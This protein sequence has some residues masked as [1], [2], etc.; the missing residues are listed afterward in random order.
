MIFYPWYS[1]IFKKIASKNHLLRLR[2]KLKYKK[3]ISF[4]VEESMDFRV[5]LLPFRE[6]MSNYRK[7]YIQVCK[8]DKYS[9]LNKNFLLFYSSVFIRQFLLSINFVTAGE[10]EFYIV[11]FNNRGHQ[12][13]VSFFK[14]FKFLRSFSTGY[15]LTFLDVFKKNL[16]Q[17]LSS[18]ILQFKFVLGV[19]GQ[20]F[21]KNFFIINIKG[22]KPN[23]YKWLNFLKFNLEDFNVLIYVYTPVI[24][25]GNNNIKSVR[26]IKRRLKKKYMYQ[27]R[28]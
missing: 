27:D 10:K 26:A 20:L 15:V 5:I 3:K 4:E 22:T 25:Y 23:F 9:L 16:R 14:K 1:F 8:F 17:K 6:L 24:S 19:I 18:F 7:L 21:L 13:F 12:I 2:F 11:L 28:I